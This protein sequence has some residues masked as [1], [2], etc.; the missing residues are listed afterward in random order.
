MNSRLEIWGKDR[1]REFTS[2]MIEDVFA[3]QLAGLGI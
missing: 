1:W 3:Q 2:R